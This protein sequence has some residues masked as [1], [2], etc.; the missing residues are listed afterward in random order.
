M[1]KYK[2]NITTIIT[3]LLII[4]ISSYFLINIRVIS[5]NN[6]NKQIEA[7]NKEKD[8]IDDFKDNFNVEGEED[9]KASKSALKPIGILYAPTI[10]LKIILFNSINEIALTEGAGI[11]PGSGDLSISKGQNTLITSHNG[12]STKDLFMN[13][14]KL[15]NNDVFYIKTFE[16]KINKYQV[17]HKKTVS[18]VNELDTVIKP[19]E[20]DIL[21]TLRTCVPTMINSH[22]L[23]VTGKYIGTVKSLEEIPKP[24][25]TVSIFELIMI[26]FLLLGIFLL[27][28][29]IVKYCE[30]IT[31]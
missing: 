26:G 31:T 7:F 12:A 30:R 17:F 24:T 1:K 28:F 20:D 10:D 13:L 11:I 29:E 23:H 27:I 25:F 16:D 19:T 8:K 4:L 5:R 2:I 22:R 15:N 3:S 21:M 6:Q 18:P 9:F 14:E